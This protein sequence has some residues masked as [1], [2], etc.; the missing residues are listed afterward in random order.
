[1][2]QFGVAALSFCLVCAALTWLVAAQASTTPLT[3]HPLPQSAWQPPRA[4]EGYT[5]LRLNGQT[6]SW[7]PGNGNSTT[8]ISYALLPSARTFGSALNCKAMTPIDDAIAPSAISTELF[9][10]ELA[11]AAALWSSAAAIDLSEADD[12]STADILIGTDAMPRG[13]AFTSVETE[14]PHGTRAS[15]ALICLSPAVKWKIGF[16]GNLDVYDLRLTLAHELGHALGLDHPG[17]TGTLM[18]FRYTEAYR[19]LTPGD[20]AGIVAI[21]GP[22]RSEPTL[23]VARNA[24]RLN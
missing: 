16:D 17:A 4:A 18:S 14:T 15:H 2:K 11:A 20:R 10:R 19:D 9:R 3:A 12:A 23:A 7:R 5:L 22:R 6:V 13:R 1:M 21:Y 24:R 8:K